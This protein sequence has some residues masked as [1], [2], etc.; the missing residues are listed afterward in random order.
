MYLVKDKYNNVAI[1]V[2]PN[3]PID[4]ATGL[5][6]PTIVVATIWWNIIKPDGNI[7]IFDS[8]ISQ[9]VDFSTILKCLLSIGI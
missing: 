7:M 1:P 9:P 5:P 6:I 4:P 8:W 3:A 2:M